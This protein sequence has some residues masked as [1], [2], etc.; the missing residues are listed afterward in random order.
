MN[1]KSLSSLEITAI[2]QE[3]QFLVRGKISQIYHQDPELVLQLHAVGKGKQLLKILPGK[4]LCLT[5]EKNAPDKPSGF[6]LQLRKYLDGA[7]IQSFYQKDTERIVVFDLECHK[8][9]YFLIIE[10][11][12]K[13]N[14]VLTDKDQ[15]AIA[16]LESQVW[17][18]RTVK[19]RE[20][21][22]FPVSEINY[23]NITKDKL[24]E[25]LN[26]SEKKNLATALA[27]EIGLGGVYAEEVCALVGV[28]KNK[29]P[30]DAE[31][32]EISA[33]YKTIKEL[34]GKISET[35]GY[36]YLDEIS[37]FPLQG[38]QP[39][40]ITSTYNEAIDTL[41]PFTKASPYEKKIKSIE[42]ILS[43]QQETIKSMEEQ[44][45]LNKR[46][47]ELVYENYTQLQ[48]LLEIVKE[49]RKSKEWKEVETELKKIKKISKVDL[50]NKKIIID[51]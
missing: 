33:I 7:I 2:V 26:K 51:L 6:C 29:L 46:K 17:K 36:I 12:S 42:A 28:D 25:I 49:M 13:G 30:K 11:Y 37:P 50:K 47:G 9:K 14:I 3:L 41:N 48:K 4:L 10:L 1:K 43:Q 23:K 27:M 15:V 21:Y 39:V 32:K 18:D 19:P 35:K 5:T 8:E 16:V 34:L 44:I 24:K 20:K 22:I 45:E 31:E 38:K 40:K